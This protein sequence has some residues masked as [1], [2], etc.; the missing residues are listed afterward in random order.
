M[1]EK[2]RAFQTKN[3][4]VLK[5]R[6]PTSALKDNRPK[7]QRMIPVIPQAAPKVNIEVVRLFKDETAPWDRYQFCTKLDQAGQGRTAYSKDGMFNEMLVKEVKVHGKEWLSRVK[8]IN[9]KNIVALHEALYYQ[10]SI[11]FFY[12]I[13]DVSLAQVFSTPLGTLRFHEVAAFS[14][15]ILQGLSYIH[16]LRISH[17][18]LSSENVLLSA[19]T[20]EIKIANFGTSML[21]QEYE[22][23]TDIRSVGTMIT[24][25]LEPH[26]ML[27]H[28]DIPI[29]ETFPDNLR[30]FQT[31]TRT[32]SAVELLKVGHKASIFSYCILL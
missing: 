2:I 24:E 15:E 32:T 3:D 17:G 6:Y 13:M 9:H 12:K 19:E 18:Q 7:L 31:R 26:M 8:E 10:G 23:Q 28:G 29:S 21:K 20:A 16:D 22:A 4:S 30:E 25:C 11:Y 27:R 5:R 14:R 1:A